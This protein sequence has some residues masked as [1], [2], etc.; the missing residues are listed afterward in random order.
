MQERVEAEIALL[1][2]RFPELEVRPDLWCRF[3][4]YRLPAGI[5]NVDVAELAF[6]IPAQLPG[7][8]P[9]GFWVRPSLTLKAGGVPSNYSPSVTTPLG[10][11]WGQ[12]SWAPE[13]WGPSPTV[14]TI[15]QGTNMVNFVESFA[16][17]LREG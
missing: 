3:A 16:I 6:Q 1:K 14:E 2:K 17:R 11:G 9:Y 5:W 10:D 4:Q 7:Q 12:F 15:A 8:Q 13:I